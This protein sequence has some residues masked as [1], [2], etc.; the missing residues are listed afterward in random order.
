MSKYYNIT[1]VIEGETET[2]FGSYDKS[3]CTYELEAERD[4]WK[5]EGY[6]KFK[7]ETV[8]VEEKPDSEVYGDDIDPVTGEIKE[9]EADE[10]FTED[11]ELALEKAAKEGYKV[12]GDLARLY[13]DLE[14][15]NSFMLMVTDG[16]SRPFEHD[17]Y[18][19]AMR[20]YRAYWDAVDTI[21]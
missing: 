18:K 15:A 9:E 11:E 3:D 14:D 17:S 8:E 20:C 1:A 13:L 6:R 16:M 10:E 19:E 2:L 21:G 5:G 4:S 7:I 12:E